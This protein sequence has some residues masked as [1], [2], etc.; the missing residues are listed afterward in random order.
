MIFDVGLQFATL[1]CFTV[2]ACRRFRKTYHWNVLSASLC[3]SRIPTTSIVV[4]C[5][6]K[7]CFILLICV[8][9]L[10]KEIHRVM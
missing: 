7:N 2:L 6:K 3:S 5:L 10:C 4:I 9:Q 1:V 8:L